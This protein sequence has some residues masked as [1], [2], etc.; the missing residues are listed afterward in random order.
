[1]AIGTALTGTTALAAGRTISLSGVTATDL[2]KDDELS[3]QMNGTESDGPG[4]VTP[5]L[6]IRERFVVDDN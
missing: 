3:L 2:A 4:R 1:M 5:I 6:E